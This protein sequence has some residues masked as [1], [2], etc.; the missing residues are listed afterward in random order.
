MPKKSFISKIEELI[1]NFTKHDYMDSKEKVEELL[2][3]GKSNDNPVKSIFKSIDSNGMQVFT[4]GDENA[5]NT[6]VYIHGGAY[7][8]EINLLKFLHILF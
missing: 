2:S 6:I 3:K 1:L 5:E 8:G 7:I 4:F